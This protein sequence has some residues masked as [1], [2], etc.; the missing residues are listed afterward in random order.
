[1]WIIRKS[2]GTNMDNE[3]GSESGKCIFY[4]KLKKPFAAQKLFLVY[5]NNMIFNYE[6]AYKNTHTILLAT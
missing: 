1:M 5:K 6:E 2:V 4:K 3:A